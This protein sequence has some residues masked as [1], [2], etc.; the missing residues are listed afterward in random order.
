MY[1]ETPSPTVGFDW[2]CSGVADR[3]PQLVVTVECGVVPPC[4]TTLGYLAVPPPCGGS[5][6]WGTC[7]KQMTLMCAQDVIEPAKKMSC[8]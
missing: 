1:H 4:P 3:D 2:D 5:A 7:V 8:K 6:A